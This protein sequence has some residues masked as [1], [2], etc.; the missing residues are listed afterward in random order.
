MAT[1]Q[2][3]VAV[4]KKLELVEGPDDADVV[5]TV[6]VADAAL[7]PTV[8]FMQGKLKATGNTGLLFTALADGAVARAVT[9]AAAASGAP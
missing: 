8:A 4:A 9:G 3:R 1:V 5:V 7:D 6:G 2:A